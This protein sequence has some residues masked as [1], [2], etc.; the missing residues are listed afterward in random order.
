MIFDTH[1]HYTDEQFSDID[2]L[3]K[4]LNTQKSVSE[5]ITCGTD[6]SSSLEC[7]KLSQKYPFVY[8][9]IGYHPEELTRTDVDISALESLVNDRV[10]AIGEIGLDYYWNKDNKEKQQKG[11][12]AQIELAKKLSLPVI[13][14]DREAHGDT[15][16]I[17]KEYKPKGVVHCFSG[18]TEMASEI[19]KLGM[20]IGVGGVVTFKNA[21]NL[22]EV[23]ENM[24]LDRLLLETDAPYLA[25]V[26]FRSKR[27]DSSL[28]PYVA[29]RIGDIKGI[30]ATQVLRVT[31]ENAYN[32]FLKSKKDII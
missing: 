24:P 4:I 28:I 13:V 15:L 23:V 26:P 7:I 11:F 32:L 25:P 9:A 10:V 16:S 31:R 20:Y 30:S 29:E 17:L 2:E 6:I 21:K 14:H 22:P 19:I 12:I 27:N 3:L 5:I 8:A 1:A 18:S